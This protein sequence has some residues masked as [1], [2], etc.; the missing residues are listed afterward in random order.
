M[1]ESD[2]YCTGRDFEGAEHCWHHTGT[3]LACDPPIYEE[4]CCYCGE[5]KSER[6]FRAPDMLNH[7]KYHPDKIVIVCGTRIMKDGFRKLSVVGT[8]ENGND[9]YRYEDVQL[10]ERKYLKQ[11]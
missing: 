10:G 5:M 9:L 1:N 7:G 3:V 6:E 2:K 8:D 11:I 4:R